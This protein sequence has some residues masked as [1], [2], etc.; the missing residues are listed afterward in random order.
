[1]HHEDF[2]NMDAE[3][4]NLSDVVTIVPYRDDDR[5]IYPAV[6]QEILA[7]NYGAIATRCA[8]QCAPLP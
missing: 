3:R 8:G 6:K 7:H 1:M 5:E 2:P 4:R